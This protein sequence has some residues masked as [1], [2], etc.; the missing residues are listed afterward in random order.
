[1]DMVWF[2]DNKLIFIRVY[3]V[4]SWYVASAKGTLVPIKHK[5]WRFVTTCPQKTKKLSVLADDSNA[6]G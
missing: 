4:A 3:G 2:V 1:M 6:I 5:A